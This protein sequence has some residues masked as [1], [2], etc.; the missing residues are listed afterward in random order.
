MGDPFFN[1]SFFQTVNR[2]A[3]LFHLPSTN[4]LIRG[5]GSTGMQPVSVVVVPPFM[6]EVICICI[7]SLQKLSVSLMRSLMRL[8]PWTSDQGQGLRRIMKS[9][10]SSRSMG[11]FSLLHSTGAYGILYYPE[12]HSWATER[13]HNNTTQAGAKKRHYR[14]V[15]ANTDP[16]HFIQL[17]SSLC[18]LAS[19][20]F[21]KDASADD[22]FHG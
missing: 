7:Q 5:L 2:C 17:W 11:R 19:F 6:S 16:C 9:P 18:C 8:S 13:R 15:S 12:L 22:D 4:A 3:V 20:Y 10:I 1:K 21:Y 14:L